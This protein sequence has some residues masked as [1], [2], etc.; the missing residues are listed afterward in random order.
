M[1]PVCTRSS[2]RQRS[3]LPFM[4][5][6]QDAPGFAESV[7]PLH[8]KGNLQSRSA[9]FRRV[10]QSRSNRVSGCCLPK[11][12]VFADPGGDFCR[13]GPRV[14]QFGSSETGRELQKAAN[15]GLF[16]PLRGGNSDLGT[17]WLG[18][19]DSNLRMGES[20]SPALPLGDAPKLSGKRRDGPCRAFLLATP[21]YRGT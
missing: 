10:R 18:R 11:T 4:N 7:M 12:G 9:A 19:E 13:N 3:G 2:G 17:A 5:S 14:L 15:S 8:A 16:C 1:I 20:K 21:V 6:L